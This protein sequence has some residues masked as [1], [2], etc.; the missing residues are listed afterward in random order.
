MARPWQSVLHH[1]L[2]PSTCGWL[3]PCALD[4]VVPAG[5]VVSQC[6]EL[7]VAM[8]KKGLMC[9][10]PHEH[11]L[12]QHIPAEVMQLVHSCGLPKEL[13]YLKAAAIGCEELADDVWVLHQL[14]SSLLNAICSRLPSRS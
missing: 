8:H 9:D 2:E 10:T 1:S 6:L 4:G 7:A 12:L 3:A 13:S 5:V 14:K 11:V